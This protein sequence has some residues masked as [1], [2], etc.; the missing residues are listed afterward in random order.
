MKKLPKINVIPASEQERLRLHRWIFERE[1]D[2]ALRES[3]SVLPD[4]AVSEEGIIAFPGELPVNAPDTAI[5]PVPGQ[6]RLLR[7]DSQYTDECPRYLAILS[8]WEEDTV[9][10]APFSR[11]AEPATGGEWATRREVSCLRTLCLWNTHTVPADDLRDSWLADTLTAEELDDAWSVFKSCSTGKELPEKLK[12]QIGPPVVHPEDPRIL[13]QEEE[14]AWMSSWIRH[15][16]F[17]R[18]VK[19]A[20]DENAEIIELPWARGFAESTRLALAADSISYHA[21]SVMYRVGDTGLV[22]EVAAHSNEVDCTLTVYDSDGELSDQLNGCCIAPSEDSGM[23]TVIDSS[24]TVVPLKTVLNGF[25]MLDDE[26]TVMALQE[27]QE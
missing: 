9:L 20:L 18:Q 25:I 23:I 3:A 4:D 21:H 8:E 17:R 26:G 6:I 16:A 13:Y 22:L 27:I 19:T 15:Q 24:R 5:D 10:A 7:P 14:V 12:E 1:T 11:Y 2:M